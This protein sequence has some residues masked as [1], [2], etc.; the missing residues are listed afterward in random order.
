[1]ICNY[2]DVLKIAAG[3]I[4][5]KEK[6]SNKDLDSKT[7]NAGKG[8][9]TKY[10]RDTNGFWGN[11]QGFDWCTT[12]VLWCF[13]MAS[14]KT[15]AEAKA[16]GWAD[17]KKVQPYGQYGASCKWQTKYYKEAKCWSDV[18]AVGYQA[19][20]TRG[21][22]GLVEKFDGK[23]LT[24]IE[25]NS[26]NQVARRTYNWPDAQFSGFGKPRYAAAPAPVV[27]TKPAI[28][29]SPKAITVD[30]GKT[31]SF[32]V[33]ATG[34]ALKY[35]WQYSPDSGKTW[36]LC[37]LP[38]YATAE[39]KVEALDYRS[40]Y[41][42]RCIVSN[43]AGSATSAGAKLTV[44]IKPTITSQPKSVVAEVNQTVKFSVSATGPNLSYQWEFSTDGG[45]TYKTWSLRAGST[46]TITATK[47]IDGRK[48]RCVVMNSF[49]SAT[50]QVATL[51]IK[52]TFKPY[53]ATVTPDIGLNVRKGPGTMNDKLGALKKGTKITILEEKSGWGRIDYNGSEGWVS[54]QYTKKV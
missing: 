23:K 18:P 15:P 38:G 42:Y 13:M 49:G 22:T 50:S 47:A 27:V 44:A 8:N 1:M 20:F 54:L 31:A 21:H 28:G 52:E 6:K 26:G 14:Y 25:G 9:Y 48:Y 37:T 34:T 2:Q 40:G 24:L 16:A 7:A 43:S 5:Y 46:E 12:F 53:T 19:F 39:L 51:S 33:T 45:L 10:A 30:I 4:G 11:K 32:T 36:K 17:I 29:K 41:M 3:E 35:Q